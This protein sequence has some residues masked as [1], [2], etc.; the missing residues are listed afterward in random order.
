MV[1]SGSNP[2]V[3][4][5]A[6]TTSSSRSTGRYAA[7]KIDDFADFKR[8]VSAWRAETY[9]LSSVREKVENPS[10]RKIVSM[11]EKSVPWVVSEIRTTPDFLVM[12]LGFLIPGNPIPDSARGKIN[13]IVDFWLTWAER[14]NPHAD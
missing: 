14:T 5:M 12:A 4:F 11:G 7:N 8:L 13:E 10:F 3:G 1:F 6:F 2:M 9:F